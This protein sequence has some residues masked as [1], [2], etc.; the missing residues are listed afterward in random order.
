ML[1]VPSCNIGYVG[2]HDEWTALG[3]RNADG[4]RL[5]AVG[6]GG[7]EALL[8]PRQYLLHA[9]EDARGGGAA[10]PVGE[11]QAGAAA[12]RCHRVHV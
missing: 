8:L 2:S 3:V 12:L 7:V 6:Y 1:Q 5:G 11:H 4:E 9:L 10:G